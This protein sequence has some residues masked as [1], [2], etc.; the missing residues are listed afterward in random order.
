VALL[1]SPVAAASTTSGLRG[2][3]LRG[4]VTPVCQVGVACDKPAPHVLLVF[5]RGGVVAGR[6]SSDANG[7][8]RIALTAGTYLVRIPSAKLGFAPR[9]VAVLPD[10]V[11]ARNFKIDTGIR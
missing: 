5:V 7:R 9:R 8:Y 1:C 11:T 4:P 10:R 3:V 6:T 2:L